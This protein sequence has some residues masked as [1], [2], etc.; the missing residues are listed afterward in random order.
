MTYH[1]T[2]QLSFTAGG[3]KA[4]T[5]FTVVNFAD[6][7]QN[8]I[9]TEGSG[10]E[11]DTP[12]TPKL[13]VNFQAD[14]NNLIYASWS[15][16]FRAAGANPPVPTDACSDDLGK[17][18][19]AEAPTTYKSDRVTSW[20]VGS[21]NKLLGGKLTVDAS[22]FTSNWNNIQQIVNLPTCAIRFIAN[23]GKARSKGF[24]LQLSATPVHG[25]TLDASVGYTHTRYTTDAAL[26]PGGQDVVTAGDA[27]EGP[28]WT[29][30]AGAQYDFPINDLDFYVR[31]DVE[32]QSRLKAPTPER[33]PAS[34]SYD[35]ALLAPDATTFISLRAGALVHG[36]NV[37]LFVD[38]LLDSAPQLGYTHEDVDTQLFENSTFRPRTVGMTVT[39]RK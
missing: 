16:G 2:D 35:P 8:G 9:R 23:V 36:A 26:A 32:Y 20:E 38:N 37:S 1:V 3:R 24:D 11:S 17:L 22:I 10:K 34:E 29:F 4:K 27:I 7:S 39:Y 21:K 28:P 14:R 30:S 12:F 15:K 13:G 18:G 31:G 19:L 33:D 6:G 5:K 25:V